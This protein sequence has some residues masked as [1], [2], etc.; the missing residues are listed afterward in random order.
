MARDTTS[1][2]FGERKQRLVLYVGLLFAAIAAILV[3]VIATKA[4]GGGGSTQT[5]PAVV[6]TQDIPADTRVTEEM[7]VVKYLPAEEVE[8]EAFTARSQVFDRIA[9]Q[10]VAEGEQIVPTLVTDKAGEGVSFVVQPG[11]RAISVDVREVVTA[12]GNLE[13]GDQ[14]DIVGIFQVSDVESANY[15]LSI[16]GLP[17]TVVE[18]PRPPAPEPEETEE[19]AADSFETGLASQDSLVLTVTMFQDVKL[20]AIAQSLTEDTAGGDAATEGEDPEPEPAAVTAT[21]ELTPQ[22]AQEITW[23]DVFGI[24]RMDA[25]AVGDD[26]V[27]DVV[28]TLFRIQKVQ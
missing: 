21:V 7:L 11:Y 27:M 13:P 12:G 20:L 2:P 17:Y 4:G 28:P 9:T 24:L 25:R 1:K 6:A 5:L 16:L 8:A 19:G 26:E 14:V 10:E 3:V 23:A 18:P 15:L 22:Q